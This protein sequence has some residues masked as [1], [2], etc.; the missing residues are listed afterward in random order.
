MTCKKP[1]PRFL[2][3]ALYRG[4]TVSKLQRILSGRKSLLYFRK[5]G[6][7]FLSI[8]TELFLKLLRQSLKKFTLLNHAPLFSGSL[9]HSLSSP[10]PKHSRRQAGRR[11]ISQLR[12]PFFNPSLFLPPPLQQLSMFGSLYILSKLGHETRTPAWPKQ[13]STAIRRVFP[14]FIRQ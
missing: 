11:S 3:G 8:L 4:R 9:L 7:T 6:S 10:P 14:L 5:G 2:L 12:P 13:V 1:L